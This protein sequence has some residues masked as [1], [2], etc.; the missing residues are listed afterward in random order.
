MGICILTNSPGDSNEQPHFETC[1]FQR[2]WKQVK[3][4]ACLC[5]PESQIPFQEV[6]LQY[7]KEP[8]LEKHSQAGRQCWNDF[9]TSQ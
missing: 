7:L 8:T 2:A 4:K 3:I 5:L 6:I 9:I 1:G